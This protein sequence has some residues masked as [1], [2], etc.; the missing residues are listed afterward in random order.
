[1]A[2]PN[3]LKFTNLEHITIEVKETMNLKIDGEYSIFHI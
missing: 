1:M 2:F 3:E